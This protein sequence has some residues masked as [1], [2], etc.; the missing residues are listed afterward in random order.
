MKQ[1]EL[2][3]TLVPFDNLTWKVKQSYESLIRKCSS[4]HCSV[5][6]KKSSFVIVFSMIY[7][8]LISESPTVD[9]Q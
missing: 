4:P 9:G 5:G 6:I 1:N 2:I 3:L 7:F 8:D